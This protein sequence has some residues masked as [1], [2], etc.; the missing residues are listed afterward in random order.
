MADRPIGARKIAVCSIDGC[1]RPH[2]ARGYCDAHH[3][4]WLDTGD[5]QPDRPIK[6][7]ASNA[8]KKCQRNGCSRGATRKG[9]CHSC[10]QMSSAKRNPRRCSVKNCGRPHY[11]HG[12]CQP[13]LARLRA[14]GDVQAD[15]PFKTERD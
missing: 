14:T 3:S 13:H 7:L 6:K 8:G 1:D 12:L 4:R 9:L 2:A 15:R 11:G 10:Y 5:P